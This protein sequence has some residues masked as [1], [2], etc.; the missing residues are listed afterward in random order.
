MKRVIVGIPTRGDD[1]GCGL[2]RF[3]L[4]TISEKNDL[5]I[6]VIIGQSG[7]SAA[8]AVD[9]VWEMLASQLGSFDYYLQIDTDIVPP[10]G[11][12][13]SMIAKDKDIVVAPIWH[14]DNISKDI[15]LNIHPQHLRQR[16][17]KI[18]VS[19]CEKIYSSSLG[20][21]LM[22]HKVVEGFIK[23]KE[24]PIHWSPLLGGYT[25]E[26]VHND[27]VFFAK[28]AKLGYE[29]WV[30]WDV[31]GVIHNRKIELSTEVLGRF[32]GMQRRLDA[33]GEAKSGGEGP[34]I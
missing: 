4:T 11:A 29:V 24:S 27:N 31:Q 33:E 14:Y 25:G 16:Q 15:H 12:I 26:D 32:V 34:N 20:F 22:K 18:R 17:Y 30:D 21:V 9:K 1:I 8:L 19:G 5:A 6:N 3:L 28:A 2:M 23:T 13:E 10:K 7:V